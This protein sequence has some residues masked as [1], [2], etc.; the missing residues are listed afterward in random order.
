[1]KIKSR[2]LVIA[3]IFLGLFGFLLA[4]F[5]ASNSKDARVAEDYL[6]NATEPRERYGEIT[7][8]VLLGFRISGADRGQS[9]FTFWV[10]TPDR[11]RIIRVKIDK[12]ATPWTVSELTD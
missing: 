12:R 10:D 9:Y 5:S 6:L 1:V 4:W 3:T 2:S 8:P 11:R 7:D